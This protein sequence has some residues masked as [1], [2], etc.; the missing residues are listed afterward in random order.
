RAR[1]TWDGSL[2]DGT[3]SDRT[4][5]DHVGAGGKVTAGCS[6][7]NDTAAA[8]ALQAGC[9]I[10]VAGLAF[11]AQGNDDFA[12]ARYN[13]DGSLDTTFGP[14][15]D[16]K[17]TTNFGS[18][19]LASALLIQP[20]GRI[21]VGGQ[22]TGSGFVGNFALTRYNADGSLDT[23]FGPNHDGKVLT[24]LGGHDAI[25]ALALLNDGRI[26]AAGSTSNPDFSN[27]NIALVRYSSD[28]SIDSTFGTAGHVITDFNG[29]ND[30]AVAITI[31]ADDKIVVAGLAPSAP[32]DGF[33]LARYER[34]GVL[35]TSFGPDHDGKVTTDI[36]QGTGFFH[37]D[38][39]GN[40]MA[41]QADSKIVVAGSATR[42]PAPGIE[43]RQK[44]F[45]IARYIS[46]IAG[47]ICLITC[48]A[49]V[50]VFNDPGL[51]GANVNY[52]VPTTG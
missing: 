50:S 26:I 40:A 35:D 38:D 15:H 33:A 46:S 20:D 21:L 27:F 45:A 17:V 24:D 28:G 43:A 7:G 19:D 49:N 10:V 3:A 48:P 29:G 41:I 52:P 18:F 4:P 8:I 5:G 2:D 32:F 11:N 39:E 16:G 37:G 42:F 22:A 9:K 13:A 6:A 44:D 14:N 47:P 30:F 36:Y 31:Q 34:D 12:L 23:S 1:D 51:G 25:S